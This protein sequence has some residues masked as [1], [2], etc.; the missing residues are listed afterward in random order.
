MENEIFSGVKATEHHFRN[1]QDE[2]SKRGFLNIPKVHIPPFHHS[3]NHISPISHVPFPQQEH[4]RNGYISSLEN[5]PHNFSQTFSYPSSRFPSYQ[6]TGN[7]SFMPISGHLPT[8]P[9]YWGD[10]RHY[11]DHFPTCRYSK[12]T[13]P[14]ESC[15]QGSYLLRT[16]NNYT[17]PLQRA[18]Q[19]E[20]SLSYY[21][22]SHDSYAG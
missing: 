16:G 11:S 1:I 22:R 4:L 21:P 10:H 17:E 6:E 14:Y 7:G 13:N 3:T 12:P 20:H 8:A 15:G 19:F 9:N 2:N 5:M 18:S